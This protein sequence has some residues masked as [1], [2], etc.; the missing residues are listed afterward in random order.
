MA[1]GIGAAL[2]PSLSAPAR[3]LWILIA[4]GAALL[5]IPEILYLKDAFDGSALFRMNTVFKAGYQ[6][7]LL[8]GLAAGVRAAVGRRLAAA[9]RLDAVGGDRLGAADPRPRLPLRGQLRARPAASPTRP[10][11][12]A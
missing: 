6:A 11:W 12:T 9:A 10:R 1:A 7:F 4:G 5:L 3:F 2:S 8:L